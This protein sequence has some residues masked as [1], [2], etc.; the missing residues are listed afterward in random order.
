MTC[1]PLCLALTIYV[2]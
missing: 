1:T 2:K